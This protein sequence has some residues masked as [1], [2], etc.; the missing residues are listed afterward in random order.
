MARKVLLNFALLARF[1]KPA[2]VA[3]GVSIARTLLHSPDASDTLK[4]GVRLTIIRMKQLN[5]TGMLKYYHG[6]AGW[7]QHECE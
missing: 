1:A 2:A 3:A 4:K 6:L 5:A 7:A